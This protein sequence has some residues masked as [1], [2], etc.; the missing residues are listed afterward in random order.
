MIEPCPVER[1]CHNWLSSRSVATM[2]AIRHK[3]NISDKT[4]LLLQYLFFVFFFGFVHGDDL[5]RR[6]FNA[7]TT[8]TRRERQLDWCDR[9][10][11]GAR[12]GNAPGLW[13]YTSDATNI[14]GHGDMHS[15][16]LHCWDDQKKRPCAVMLSV[17]SL[18]GKDAAS[19]A[20]NASRDV[21]G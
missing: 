20:R 18:P 16:H 11:I 13:Y 9:E 15:K 4:T 6:L 1:S 7:G 19:A 2:R 21:W 14:S 17:A 5:A 10:K 3:C 8:Y 12:I